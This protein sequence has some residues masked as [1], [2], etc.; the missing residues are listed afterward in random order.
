MLVFI[1]HWMIGYLGAI[2]RYHYFQL[3]LKIQSLMKLLLKQ[4]SKSAQWWDSRGKRLGQGY[5]CLS[6]LVRSA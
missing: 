4:R 2:S 1:I 6:V 3:V 5:I